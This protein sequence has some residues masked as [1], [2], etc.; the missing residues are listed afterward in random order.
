ME[1]RDDDQSKHQGGPW[2]DQGGPWRD[3]NTHRLVKLKR[4]PT[5]ENWEELAS[6]E[7]SPTT[8]KI[9][10]SAFGKTAEVP[11]LLE[12]ALTSRPQKKEVS[13]RSLFHF[14]LELAFHDKI[15]RSNIL[16][17]KS[18]QMHYSSNSE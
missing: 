18:S 3:Q 8:K 17:D 15:A 2:G 14:A 11:G 5:P 4:P 6:S 1:K 10:P 12:E 16:H 9:V 7:A 13:S